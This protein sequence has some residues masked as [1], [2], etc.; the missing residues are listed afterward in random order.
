MKKVA[1]IDDEAPARSLLR[2]YLSEY[3]ELVI[4]G[5]ANNG[6]DAIQLIKKFQPELVFLDIQMPG[7]NGFEVL[8][9][10]EE[11]PQIIFSTA[12]DQYAL[13]AFEVNAV[14]YLL[15]PY[16]KER[17]SRSVQRVMQHQEEN[18]L[19]LKSLAETLQQEVLNSP[20]NYP[21]KILISSKN[22]LLAIDTNDIVWI[23]AEKDYSQLH[24]NTQRYLSSYGIGQIAEKL[25]PD[26]FIRVHRSSIIN[27]NYIDEI[28]K[29]PSSYDV[30]MKNGDVVR[31][32]RSYLDNIRKLTF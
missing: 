6:V 29:Y 8:Q 23:E 4:I 7:M 19:K 2:E 24:T 22:R 31:V 26:V 28:F 15:K 16:T 3:P 12:Y 9:Q 32:S 1:L 13:R 21:S 17:F 10:L 30:K 25:D 20:N 18:L 14:D 27:L 11:V 5:E